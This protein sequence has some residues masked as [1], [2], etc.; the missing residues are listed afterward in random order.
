MCVMSWDPPAPP[1]IKPEERPLKKSGK[2]QSSTQKKTL[3]CIDVLGMEPD[4][5]GNTV[6]LPTGPDARYRY[7]AQHGSVPR[8]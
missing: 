7:A 1:L 3:L 2:K 6:E 8:H 5:N 4:T